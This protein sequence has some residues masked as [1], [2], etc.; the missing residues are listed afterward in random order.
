MGGLFDFS[1]VD[2]TRLSRWPVFS[3]DSFLFVVVIGL[4]SEGVDRNESEHAR[5]AGRFNYFLVRDLLA[6][7]V[8]QKHLFVIGLRKV[9][10]AQALNTTKLAVK[11]CAGSKNWRR[12]CEVWETGDSHPD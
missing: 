1:T 2:P 9:N 8:E 6:I 11:L 10:K 12:E 4:W 5:F 3:G 7:V